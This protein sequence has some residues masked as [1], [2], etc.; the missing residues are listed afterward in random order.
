VI[1]LVVLALAGSS[2]ADRESRRIQAELAVARSD[3]SRRAWGEALVRLEAL[4]RSWRYRGSGEVDYRLGVCR[5]KLGRRQ[6]AVAALK[7][8]PSGSEF[9]AEAAV[10]LAE[11][12][13]DQ[14]RLSA[15]ED[16][17]L[18]LLRPGE[19]GPKPVMM[20]LMWLARFEAR[21]DEARAWM[22]AAFDRADE[23]IALLRQLWLLDRG[24]VPIDGVR[25]DLQRW[26]ARS[27]DE[28]RVWLGLGRV[29]ILAGRLDEAEAWLRRCSSRRAGDRAVERTW[30]DWA[31]AAGRADELERIL[32]GPLGTEL[33]PA[34][35]LADRVWLAQQAG[36]VDDVRRGLEC[37]LEREPRNPE[38]LARLATLAAQDGEATRAAELRRRKARVDD[39][40]ARYSSRI[41]APDLFAS[42]GDQVAMAQLAE[43]A[44]RTFDARAWCTLAARVEPRHPEVAA[45]RA[46]LDQ[47]A[48]RPSCDGEW[49]HPRR[50]APRTVETAAGTMKARHVRV[51]FRDDAPRAGLR[52]RFESGET[53]LHQ[54]PE[55]MSGGVGLLDYDGDGWLDVYCVQGGPFPPRG[56]AFQ[57]VEDD[58]GQDARATGGAHGQDDS[59]PPGDRLFHNRGDGTFEDVTHSAGIAAL[60]RG[61]GHGVAVG[62]YDN[63]GHPD[64][65][66]T[67][68]RAYALYRNRGDGTFEDVTGAAGLGGDRDWPTSAAF[69][70]LDGDGDLDLYVCHYLRWDAENPTICRDPEMGA[71]TSCSPLRFAGQPDHVFRNQGG[72]F[73]DA[74]T[75]SGVVEQTGRGLGV[76]AAD[77]DGD[78]RV[79]LFVANDQTANALFRNLGGFRFEEVG[80][81]AGVAGNAAGGYQAGMGV[82]CGDLDGDG[83]PDLAVTNF[84][85]EST[86]LYRNLGAGLFTDATAVS[87]LAVPS[88]HLLGFGAWFFDV[89]NDGRL[90]LLTANGHLDRL[91]GIPYAMPMQLLLGDGARLRD[92]TEASGA[93]LAVPRIARGLAVGDL[94]NDG[95]LDAIVIDH[96]GP[97][98]YLHNQTEGGGHFV[99]LGLE[100]IHSSRDAVGSRVAV[101]AGGRRQFAWRLGGGSYQSASDGRLHFGLGPAMRIE[102]IEVAWPSGRI[103]RFR[104]LAAD[105][106]YWLREGQAQPG[107]LPGFAR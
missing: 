37:W 71:Y 56:T 101:T 13:L 58:H 33:E 107:P 11:D 89:D 52:F 19:P 61:Y 80:H 27:P 50:G 105:R 85:G 38:V 2:L 25:S 23:P 65:F 87:G 48:A 59:A 79:D 36:W 95:R 32:A 90:D 20:L 54:I 102:A 93:A 43:E 28:D 31:R 30:R 18:G 44:G 53:P 84:Y 7:R 6:A 64:L 45:I 66:I 69:A 94:D 49:G 75:G 12:D 3:M 47:A 99:V 9:G 42:L 29:E 88:R 72:R 91:P 104:D 77:L 8:V 55:V 103:Q 24:A 106:G 78:G 60:S 100:G 16:R 81:L 14:G 70:D 68:W 35:R 92:V 51:A 10:L 76:V 74:T 39:A 15:A 1:A 26:L 22:R 4:V 21:Y 17:L 63:D 86:T 46:W 57:A 83:H 5:W 62:D 97:L 41:K 82:A 73:V 96:A 67:R 34:E 98:A 40:L